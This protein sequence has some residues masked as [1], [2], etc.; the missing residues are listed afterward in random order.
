MTATR[1]VDKQD[2]TR[3]YNPLPCT[4]LL[5]W[6]FGPWAEEKRSRNPNGSSLFVTMHT[7]F[8]L[9]PQSLGGCTFSSSTS[10]ES[11]VPWADEAQTTKCPPSSSLESPL[12]LS[13]LI[14]FIHHLPSVWRIVWPY[15]WWHALS[16]SASFSVHWWITR[17]CRI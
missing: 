16:T 4:H 13:R 12:P 14:T 11:L 8:G 9:F 7:L 15:R 17:C 6:S 5:A 10:L 2:T 3:N 1:L